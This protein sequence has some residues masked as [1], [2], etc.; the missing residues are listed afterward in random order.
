MESVDGTGPVRVGHQLVDM[1]TP[2]LL[3]VVTHRRL[4][5]C[6]DGR[7][8]RRRGRRKAKVFQVIHIVTETVTME[9]GEKKRVHKHKHFDKLINKW[10]ISY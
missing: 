3:C 6:Q 1:A 5:R 10:K 4:E 8:E 2:R 7:E 9:T